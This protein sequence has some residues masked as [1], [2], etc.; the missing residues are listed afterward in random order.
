MGNRMMAAGI[1]KAR[2]LYADT[3][4]Y[5]SAQQH[6][7]P[8]YAELGFTPRGEPYDE[9]GIMHVDMILPAG[10]NVEDGRQ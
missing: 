8:F 4:L 9:D 3:T 5:I 2:Q 6:L 1:R 7:I 10:E